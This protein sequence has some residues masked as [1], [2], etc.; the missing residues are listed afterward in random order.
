M[1]APYLW[2]RAAALDDGPIFMQR[3]ELV[4]E[5][6]ALQG[7]ATIFICVEWLGRTS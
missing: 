1:S 7:Q 5:W 4:D 6:R 2:G 3:T